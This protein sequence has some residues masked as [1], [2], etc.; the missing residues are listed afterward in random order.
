MVS[1]PMESVGGFLTLVVEM[2]SPLNSG[3]P[4]KTLVRTSPGAKICMPWVTGASVTCL[5]SSQV[6]LLTSTY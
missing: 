6:A 1:L 5:A 4:L 3:R 2:T